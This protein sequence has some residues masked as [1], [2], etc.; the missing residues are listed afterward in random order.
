MLEQA[1]QF[2]TLALNL[3]EL[4]CSLTV[5]GDGLLP[6]IAKHLA[7]SCEPDT[8]I[9]EED[10]VWWPSRDKLGRTYIIPS[11]RA[12]SKLVS[13]S[14]GRECVVQAG[15]NVGMWPKELAKYFDRVVTFEPDHLNFRCLEKNCTEPN[16]EK[17]NAALGFEP[18][19]KAL[20]GDPSN[21]GSHAVIEGDEFEVKTID[22]LELDACDLIQLDVEGYELFALK[23]AEETIK[24]FHPVICIE[25]KSLAAGYG[26]QDSEVVDWL[27]ARGYGEKLKA[28]R[29]VVF[30]NKA[31]EKAECQK[32]CTTATYQGQT[33]Q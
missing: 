5:A 31:G 4:G 3:A 27:K 17:H 8:E 29:D 19:L 14:H 24:K 13:L 2:Q 1:N 20:Y 21:C 16:I 15:G 30:V 33:V 6:W 23:G 12:V 25:L 22:S 26:I 32:E 11:L 7:K 9:V 28:G 10:G 18:G